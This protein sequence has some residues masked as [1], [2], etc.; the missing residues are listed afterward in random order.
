MTARP[1]LKD[2]RFISSDCPAC[3]C[4]TLRQEAPNEWRC[5][6]LRDPEDP[7]KE[8]EA[9]EYGIYDGEVI[10]F[11]SNIGIKGAA[12]QSPLE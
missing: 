3:G 11:P 1:R 4:G 7:N 2:G 9:C 5:D 10:G 12:K 8:L 6:G